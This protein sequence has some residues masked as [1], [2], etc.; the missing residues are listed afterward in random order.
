MAYRR[1]ERVLQRLAARHDAIIAAARELAAESG[2]DAVQIV[3]VAA[4][5]GIAAG[6]VYRYFPAK[7]ESRCRA[8]RGRA[9]REI[10]AIRQA[11]GRRAGPLSALAAAIIV[12]AARAVRGA[13][14][15]P[16]R[17]LAEPVEAHGDPPRP[18]LP[19][20]RW[21]PSSSRASALR[22]RAA[23][24]PTRTPTR[25][26]AAV[27][28]ALIEGLIGPLAPRGGATRRRAMPCR[29]SRCLRCAAL[30]V[31]DARARGLVVQTAWPAMTRGVAMRTLLQRGC[32]R[33]SRDAASQSVTARARRGGRSSSHARRTPQAA[34]RPRCRRRRWR[35]SAAP[36]STQPSASACGRTSSSTCRACPATRHRAAAVVVDERAVD[37]VAL[38]APLV[39]DDDRAR[40]PP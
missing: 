8:G 4:R 30:G 19:A 9:E 37:A 21:W 23:I 28:G 24:C 32:R 10:A 3:P 14:S 27:V 25:A 40:R 15:R 18:A 34:H 6:T 5:A 38:R 22:S 36:P 39:F 2:M 13:P 26:A 1:T 31:V 11:A 33:A 7:T 20:R 12:F 35:G 17:V 29:A 16:G